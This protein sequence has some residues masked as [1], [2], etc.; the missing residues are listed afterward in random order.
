MLGNDGHGIFMGGSGSHTITH[1]A[2]TGFHLSSISVA[3]D[4]TIV[5]HNNVDSQSLHRTAISLTG[6]RNLVEHN[7]IRSYGNGNGLGDGNRCFGNSIHIL[8][9]FVGIVAGVSN[10]IQGNVI[11]S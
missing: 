8:S 3:S 1:N 9:E 11:S 5:S 4:N 2:V 10:L 6:S 7:V